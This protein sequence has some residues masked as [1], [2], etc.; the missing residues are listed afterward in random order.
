[1]A[2]SKKEIINTLLTSTDSVEGIVLAFNIVN[3]VKY[4][5]LSRDKA[6][7]FLNDWWSSYLSGDEADLTYDKLENSFYGV[8][9]NGEI[10]SKNYLSSTTIRRTSSN[11][12]HHQFYSLKEYHA[13]Y[14]FVLVDGVT[15]NGDPLPPP[16]S[17]DLDQQFN[18][19][20]KEN[21]LDATFRMAE[22]KGLRFSKEHSVYWVCPEQDLLTIFNDPNPAEAASAF[23][24]LSHFK[25]GSYILAVKLGSE[26]MESSSG[27]NAALRSTPLDAGYHSRFKC[28]CDGEKHDSECGFTANLAKLVQNESNIDG[29]REFIVIEDN[30]I[31]VKSFLLQPLGRLKQF[32][33]GGNDDFIRHLEIAGEIKKE[34]LAIELE[35][36][37]NE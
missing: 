15:D 32:S 30:A 33:I 16:D 11:T 4:S 28:L 21:K 9:F 14:K 18:D 12:E 13:L 34:D 1:M 8:I 5:I 31:P 29:G 2:F 6:F 27:A 17:T 24:G 36:L 19:M 35:K 26:F 7:E 25:Q 20:L 10:A 3:A 37:S 23:L 22:G